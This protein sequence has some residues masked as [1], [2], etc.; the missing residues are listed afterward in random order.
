MATTP[1]SLITPQTANTPI[2]NVVLSTAMTSTKNYDGTDTAGTAL[3][4]VYTVGANGGQLPKLRLRY[5]STNGAAASGT[6][7]ATV[8]RIFFNNGSAN[9]TAAN[10]IF[11][12]EVTIPST[13]MTQTA[14][15]SQPTDYDF[16]NLV[17]PAGWKVYVGLATAVGGTNCAIAAS[18]PGGGDF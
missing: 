2:A 8:A 14:A 10:N 4:L 7:N 17:L 16:E 6:T 15:L 3:G 18:M 9:T 1:N 5:G 11:V 13:T 12:G